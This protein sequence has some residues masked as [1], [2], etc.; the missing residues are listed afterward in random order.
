MLQIEDGKITNYE[1]LISRLE[2]L[3]KSAAFTK[4]PNF[5]TQKITK[6]LNSLKELLIDSR[7]PKIAI[8]GR[9]Q[10]GK[11]SLINC[12]FG[13]KATELGDGTKPKTK[14]CEW[15]TFESSNGQLKILDSRGILDDTTDTNFDNTKAEKNFY[16][17][18][19]TECPDIIIYL[20]KAKEFASLNDNE[21]KVIKNMIKKVETI[22]GSQVPLIGVI[23]HIDILFARDEPWP[24]SE[25]YQMQEIEKQKLVFSDKIKRITDDIYLLSVVPVCTLTKYDSE[26]KINYS[27]SNNWGVEDL[28]SFI[29][30][31]LPE[32]AKLKMATAV[33]IK[34]S[35][36]SFSDRVIGIFS[37]LSGAIGAQP[38]PFGDMPILVSIQLALIMTIAYIGRGKISLKEAKDF[39]VASGANVGIGYGMRELARA[40][41]K[42]VPIA[43]NAGSGVLAAAATYAIGKAAVAY[44]IDDVKIEDVK[45]IILKSN[46]KENGEKFVNE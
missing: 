32:S 22:N 19:K 30:D 23:S 18:V 7:L 21:L 44:F 3:L 36:K 29:V 20:H 24:P 31:T 16:E 17:A 34:S 13:S 9:T 46:T 40:L 39:L 38:I 27:R 41:L 10:A 4:L 42:F 5:V 14:E 26:G 6:E 8:I 1:E 11:S 37:S 12:I 35:L 43:G 2:E 15:K 33:R 25:H 45:K 28:V